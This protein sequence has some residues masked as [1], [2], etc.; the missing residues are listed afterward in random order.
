MDVCSRA[1]LLTAYADEMYG[2]EWEHG[3]AGESGC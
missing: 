3:W 2:S 1:K